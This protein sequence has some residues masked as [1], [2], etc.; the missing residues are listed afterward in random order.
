MG[1][2]SSV[3]Q[4]DLGPPWTP[5]DPL[6]PAWHRRDGQLISKKSSKP[7]LGMIVEEANWSCWVIVGSFSH[8]SKR[9]NPCDLIDRREELTYV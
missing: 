3:E 6:G 4:W 9:K 2:R 7:E 1:R 8:S 5:L